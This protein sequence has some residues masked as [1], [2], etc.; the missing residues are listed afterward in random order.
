MEEKTR[1]GVNACV[2]LVVN[3]VEVEKHTIQEKI[4][5]ET[6][7]IK[8]PLLQFT[9]K[10]VDNPVVAQRQISMVVVVQKS[11]EIS[12]LQYSDEVINVPVVQV[13]RVPQSQVVAE[14]AQQIT[15]KVTDV[16]VV[17]VVPVP[18]VRMVKKTVEDPQ[19][20]IVEK[21]VENS[22][23]QTIQG[24]DMPVSQVQVMAK[25]VQIPQLPFVEKIDVIPEIRMALGARTSESLNGEASLTLDRTKSLSR[26]L[27]L[28]S[29]TAAGTTTNNTPPDKQCKRNREKE[30]EEREIG[31][32]GER[33]KMEA[34]RKPEEGR[35]AE[36]GKREQVKKDE[37]G[38]TVVT[39]S[40]KLRKRI[41]KIV[42][43]RFTVRPDGRTPFQYLL[44]TPLCITFVHVW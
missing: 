37:T 17:L 40:K 22:E 21:T 9:D 43:S 12:Q 18:Q 35:D 11:T 13:V 16:P 30:R 29:H 44:G 34:G 23:T 19:F 33:R 41:V 2:H 6:K 15:D 5:Q 1:Q 42:V 3:A 28:G 4:N 32:K 31:R 10:V 36:V 25:T 39:R 14:T 20:Q 8:I 27:W 24:L 26:M 7:R 38:W